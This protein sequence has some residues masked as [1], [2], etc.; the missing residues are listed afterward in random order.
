MVTVTDVVQRTNA[1]G[2][3]FVALILQGD[4]EIIESQEGNF[5]ATARKCSIPSTFTEEIALEMIGKE[6]QGTIV[7]VECKPYQY[8]I[9]ESGEVIE[10]GHRWVYHPEGKSVPRK[11][12]KAQEKP[13]KETLSENGVPALA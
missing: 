6:I 13:L 3:H 9:P 7:K 12:V 8:E 2:D 4:L 5:Y 10:L 1:E 11:P